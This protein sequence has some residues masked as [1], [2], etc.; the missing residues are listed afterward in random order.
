MKETPHE[1]AATLITFPTVPLPIVVVTDPEVAFGKT[2]KPWKGT[3][4]CTLPL[5]SKASPDIAIS[6]R[7]RAETERTAV[8]PKANCLR[9]AVVDES[10]GESK[11]KVLT[12]T[13][14]Q[15][16]TVSFVSLAK[17]VLAE[18]LMN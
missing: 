8:S 2:K 17:A 3:P 12:E 14:A 7:K 5:L 11:H 10:A 1:D 4:Q 16:V 9:A 6:P 18:M 13:A 15:T